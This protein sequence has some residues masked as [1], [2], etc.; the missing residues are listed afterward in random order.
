MLKVRMYIG[1]EKYYFLLEEI[2]EG[3][4]E[5]ISISPIRFTKPL[6]LVWYGES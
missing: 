1:L 6:A 4:I 3:R 2:I 5:D